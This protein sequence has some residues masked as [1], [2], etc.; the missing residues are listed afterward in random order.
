MNAQLTTLGLSLLLLIILVFAFSKFLNWRLN[1]HIIIE[2]DQNS[3]TLIKGVYILGVGIF[4]FQ[5]YSVLLTFNQ[6]VFQNMTG[7]ELAKEVFKFF[8]LSVS[9]TIIY[10]FL[11]YFFSNGLNYLILKTPLKVIVK[12]QN[13]VFIYLAIVVSLVLAT[14]SGVT[15]L[16]E[17]FIPYPTMP[18][19]N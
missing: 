12:S 6:I 18:I 16:V 13:M 1:K 19:F 3:I 17:R 9:I 5:F 2:E 14:S 10:F 8:S 15:L 4:L 11:I 7:Y